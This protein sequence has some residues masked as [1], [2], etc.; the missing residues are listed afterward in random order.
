MQNSN[1]YFYTEDGTKFQSK[2]RAMEYSKATGQKIQFYYHGDVYD[3]VDWQKELPENLEYYYKQQALRLREKYDYLVLT[4]SGGVDSTNI[5]ETFVRNNIKLDKILVVGAFS[6]DSAWGVD[7]NHNGEIYHNAIPYLEELG[8]MD[9]TEIVDYT[10]YICGEEFK[11]LSIYQYGLD[12]TY[13]IGSYFSVNNWFWR[14]APKIVTPA[15]CEGK[16]VGY[17]FGIDK[18]QIDKKDSQVLL[19]FSDVSLTSYGNLTDSINTD[20]INFYWD[21][22]YTDLLVKQIQELKKQNCFGPNQ[23]KAAQV[24]YKLKKPL[25]FHSPKS[26][27]Y[28]WSLRDYYLKNEKNSEFFKFYYDGLKILDEKVGFSSIDVIS[29]RCYS[30]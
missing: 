1:L 5:L 24:L 7:E 3:K 22:E 28:F 10:H 15:E 27:N 6:K 13:E 30:V 17:I 11:K 4:Y 18:P 16:K 8:L 2:I 14:D 9:I 12:W 19:S 25:K 29:T 20:K 21:P 26:R 23:K